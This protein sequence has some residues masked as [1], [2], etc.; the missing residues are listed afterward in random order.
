MEFHR[1][2]GHPWG[3]WHSRRKISNIAGSAKGKQ[4][5]QL[6]N[7]ANRPMESNIESEPRTGLET[8][9]GVGGNLECSLQATHLME[10]SNRFM[11]CASN[12]GHT[13]GVQTR[14]SNLLLQS[15]GFHATVNVCTTSIGAAVQS[16]GEARSQATTIAKE[17]SLKKRL[18]RVQM[19]DFFNTLMVDVVLG[20]FNG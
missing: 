6:T 15:S 7:D 2:G 17:S 5:T 8:S 12:V 4:A 13:I 19:H 14:R 20:Y 1:R 18:L 3:R 11:V 10:N 16:S 9:N